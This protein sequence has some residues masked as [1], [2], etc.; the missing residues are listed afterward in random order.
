MPPHSGDKVDQGL[1]KKSSFKIVFYR[2]DT[3]VPVVHVKEI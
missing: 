3:L 2:F 1:W